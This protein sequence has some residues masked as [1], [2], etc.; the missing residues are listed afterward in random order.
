[1]ETYNRNADYIGDFN[2]SIGDLTNVGNVITLR[3]FKLNKSRMHVALD[4]EDLKGK[5][6]ITFRVHDT[7]KTRGLFFKTNFTEGEAQRLPTITG[8][9]DLKMELGSVLVD[10]KLTELYTQYEV[11]YIP[12][13]NNKK[14][15]VGCKLE[16]VGKKNGQATKV[17]KKILRDLG[18][19]L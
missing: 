11:V 13:F 2:L 17:F 19:T 1:M 3:N 7:K 18:A 8:V 15:L 12:L 6:L 10:K 14:D 9:Y 5:D 16:F 4:I